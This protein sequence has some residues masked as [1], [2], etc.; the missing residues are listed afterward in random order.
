M[1]GYF[2]N[3]NPSLYSMLRNLAA[4]VSRQQAASY[5]LVKIWRLS[6]RDDGYLTYVEGVCAVFKVQ[7]N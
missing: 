4:H 7:M 3:P 1:V 5:L 6:A 2:K